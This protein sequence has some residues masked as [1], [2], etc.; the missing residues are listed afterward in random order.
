[1]MQ[2]D[3]PKD[4]S[5]IIKVIGVGGGGS[6][7]VNHMFRQGI[8][9]VD[10]IVCNTDKQALDVS[11]VPT[12]I[13]LGESLTGG[14][15]A[16]AL[17]EVGKNAAIETIDEVRALLAKNTTMVFITA[18]MGGG[19]GTGAAPIIAKLAKEM[20]ILTVGI[21]TV[22][23]TFEGR[24]RKEQAD[25]GM[26]EMREACD[27]LLV[28]KNDKLREIYGNMT[29]KEAF[30][31][32]D[33]V[34]AVAARGIAEVISITGEINVDMND[35][36]TVMSNSGLAIMG[37]G[38]AE[39]AD[40]AKK[41]V[42]LALESPLLNDNDIL[43]AKYVLLNITIGNYNVMMEE[44]FEI[45]E[46]IQQAA[47]TATDLIWGYGVDES[48]N[49]RIRVSVVAT[50]F[51]TK[52]Q[53]NMEQG[54]VQEPQRN[55]TVL[56][57]EMKPVEK[58]LVSPTE[59]VNGSFTSAP[60]NNNINNQE[61]EEEIY[62]VTKSPEPTFEVEAPVEIDLFEITP[63]KVEEVKDEV[64]PPA[65]VMHYINLDDDVEDEKPLPKIEE[66]KK[67]VALDSNEIPAARKLSTSEQQ[68]LMEERFN[69]IKE[70]NMKLRSSSGLADLEKEPAIARKNIR[71][72]SASHSSDNNYSRFSISED[73]EIRKGNSFLH[74]NVD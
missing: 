74:D 70:L 47:G 19:T 71:L 45:T 59:R 58:P 32:A 5:S 20:G 51:D 31:K 25:A 66:P 17:P 33:D 72:N 4:Q 54:Q 9:G 14:N 40:R 65:P 10:F 26:A 29:L 11:P 46:Y 44:V 41:A 21:V 34:L 39:G 49:E 37:S 18:G 57:D 42:E 30:S 3:L 67:P 62:M 48:L 12:K 63:K 56:A 23:F 55:V 35:V 15:G 64:A 6:N 60:V 7:A 27:T 73:G 53:V 43:G 68:K 50:G 52:A 38:E 13:Q 24:K 2:F 8:R 61:E 36:K 22:P 1:M 28:V 16:G 69:K